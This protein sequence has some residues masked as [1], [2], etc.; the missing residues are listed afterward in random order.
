MQAEV[1]LAAAGRAGLGL[2]APLTALLLLA[3]A[4]L[5]D[6]VEELKGEIGGKFRTLI[7]GMLMPPADFDAKCMREVSRDCVS[8]Q[9]ALSLTVVRRRLTV[10]PPRR[11][12]YRP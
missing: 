2:E 11:P 9:C 3:P 1:P 10:A 5:Q 8:G 4:C 7:L 6:L 12:F